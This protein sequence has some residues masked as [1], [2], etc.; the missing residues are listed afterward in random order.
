[1]VELGHDQPREI[2]VVGIVEDLD[3]RPGQQE[4]LAETCPTGCDI[5]TAV[6]IRVKQS[7]SVV[8][9][10]GVGDRAIVV[11]VGVCGGAWC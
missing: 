6:A 8:P 2:V 9:S 4:M 1:M 11:V 3:A 5:P 7:D 10:R